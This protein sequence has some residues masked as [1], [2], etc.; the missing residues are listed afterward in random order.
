M[1]PLGKNQIARLAAIAAPG[2][3]LIVGDDISQALIDR[4]LAASDGQPNVF[5]RITPKG[6]RHLADLADRGKVDLSIPKSSRRAQA[7]SY[8]G[9]TN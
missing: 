3:A 8:L 2:T 4:G 7:K 6:L 5:V 9:I 1:R